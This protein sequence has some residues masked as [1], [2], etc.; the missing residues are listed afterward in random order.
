M[1]TYYL[2]VNAAGV[3]VKDYDTFK[4]GGTGPEYFEADDGVVGM[5]EVGEKT[6]IAIYQLEDVVQ[7]EGLVK[8]SSLPRRR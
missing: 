7:C 3:Y 2:L 4:D 8:T 5:V 1:K 6:K